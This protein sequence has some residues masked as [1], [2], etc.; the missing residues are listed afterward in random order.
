MEQQTDCWRTG[1]GKVFQ[2]ENNKFNDQRKRC[3]FKTVQAEIKTLGEVCELEFGKRITKSKNEVK[4]NYKGVIFPVYGGGGI[5]FYTD[6]FNRYKEEGVLLIS[7][8]GVSPNCSRIVND[9]FF[10][11]DSGMSVTKYKLNSLIILKE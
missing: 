2:T 3:C 6:K 7:R 1:C 10:L 4:N 5:T 9:K 11:N 8:F